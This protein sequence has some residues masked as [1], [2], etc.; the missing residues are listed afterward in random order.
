LASFSTVTDRPDP[1]PEG[2][3][4]RLVTPGQVRSEQHRG[5]GRVDESGR[6]DADE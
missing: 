4:Q 3:A 5:A 2:V 1:A 6:T